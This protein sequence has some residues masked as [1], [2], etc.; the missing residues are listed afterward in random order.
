MTLPPEK[1]GD[2]GQRFVVQTSGWPRT[3]VMGWQNAGYAETHEGATQ[4]MRAFAKCPGV[5]HVHIKDRRP[6]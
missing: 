1:I 4:M 6:A 5:K 3:D 2:K